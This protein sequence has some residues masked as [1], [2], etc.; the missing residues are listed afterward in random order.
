MWFTERL[1][2][3]SQGRA[4][5]PEQVTPMWL[6]PHP[7]LPPRAGPVSSLGLGFPICHLRRTIG[8][9]CLS[10]LLTGSVRQCVWHTWTSVGHWSCVRGPTSQCLALPGSGWVLGMQSGRTAIARLNLLGWHHAHFTEEK[11]REVRQLLTSRLRFESG[12]LIPELMCSGVSGFSWKG[13][14]VMI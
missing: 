2:A 4:G 14:I 11:K 3:G 8:S 12:R 10:G 1:D 5:T 13:W 9:S 6:Q 7:S